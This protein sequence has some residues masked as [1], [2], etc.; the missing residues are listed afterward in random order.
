MTRTPVAETL[1]RVLGA[2][3]IF[4]ESEKTV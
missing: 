3:P 1:G 4:E 2:A